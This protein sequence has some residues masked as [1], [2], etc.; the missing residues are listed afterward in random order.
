MVSPHKLFANN[1]LDL[2]L[3]QQQFKKN[4]NKDENRNGKTKSSR[5]HLKFDLCLL[6]VYVFQLDSIQIELS[7]IKL[8]KLLIRFFFCFFF[9]V[10]FR[11]IGHATALFE[12]KKKERVC[13]WTLWNMCV[14][15]VLSPT[16][17]SLGTVLINLS[18]RVKKKKE[19]HEK[20]RMSKRYALLSIWKQKCV[21]F[22]NYSYAGFQ[23]EA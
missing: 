10:F 19:C 15:C 2:I 13:M 5:N 4:G 1:N 23:L 12:S 17:L 20:K 6:K 9:I 7:R 14:L 16:L 18:T 3:R 8:S 22:T 21:S 11:L